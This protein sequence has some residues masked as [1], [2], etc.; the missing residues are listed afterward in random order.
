[1]L[2]QAVGHF[3]ASVALL[4]Q[5]SSQWCKRVLSDHT[6]SADSQESDLPLVHF[7][8]WHRGSRFDTEYLDT[9]LMSSV[10]DALWD[11]VLESNV[12]PAELTTQ[13]VWQLTQFISVCFL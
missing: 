13:Q 1:M 3:Y 9:F 5:Q 2:A 11:L 12:L 4:I 7:R 10:R 6:F 8:V